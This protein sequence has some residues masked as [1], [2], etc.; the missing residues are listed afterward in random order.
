MRGPALEEA[1]EREGLTFGHLPQ[2]WEFATVGGYAATRSAGQNSAGVG[3]FDDLVAGL[4][5][6][7]PSGVLELGTPPASA[8]GPDLL[9]LA[10]GSEGTLGIITELRLRVRPRPRSTHYEGWSFRSWAAGLAALQRLARHGL[11]P[12]GGRLSRPRGTRGHLR[13]A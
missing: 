9:G 10:L 2:S 13:I 5:L 8:A 4:T 1:L 11:L 6:A 3:R 12:D 7:T